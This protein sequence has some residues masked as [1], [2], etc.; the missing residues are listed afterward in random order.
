VLIALCVLVAVLAIG[1]VLGVREQDVPPLP[2]ENPELKHLEER[3]ATLFENLKDLQFEYLQGKLS[4]EDYQA[5]KQNFQNDLAVVMASIDMQKKSSG[6]SASASRGSEKPSPAE[7]QTAAI[8]CASC[9]AENSAG[10]RFCGSCGAQ[11]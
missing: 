11:L 1:F 2:R 3:R 9:D 4:D 7:R 10:Q 8:R 6:S 5:L